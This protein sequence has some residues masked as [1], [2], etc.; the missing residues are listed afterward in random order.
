M[1]KQ[2]KIV[3][4]LGPASEDID[5]LTKMVKAGMNVA[6]LNFSHGKYENHKML[7]K[8]IRRVEEM[9]G[10]PVAILQDL[11]GPKLRIGEMPDKGL[12]LK[13]GGEIFFKTGE[14]KYTKKFIPI[15][16]P[17][18]EKHLQIGERILLDD[19]KMEVEILN[20]KKGQIK[21]KV[22][23]GGVL[24]SKKGL[25]LPDSKL[26]ISSLTEKDKEDLVFGVENDVD[27]MA[28]S[29]VTSA[30]DILDLRYLIKEAEKKLHKKNTQPIRIIAK[31]E[32]RE[33][34]ENIQEILDVADGI[35]V[36]RGDLGL[37][38]SAAKVPLVQKNLIDKA[39]EQAK[40]V[41]VATQML[42]SM[43]HN[44]RPTRAEVSDVAN[45]VIDHTD[46]VMLSNET[47]VGKYPVVVVETMAEIASITEKSIYDDLKIEVVND[48]HQNTE[49]IDKTICKMSRNLAEQVGA[50]VILVASLSGEAGRLISRFRPNL[51][52]LVATASKRIQ[53]QLNLSRGV[54][55]FIL[56]E[57]KSIEELVDRSLLYLKKHHLVKVDDKIVVVAGEP[58][59]QAGNINLLEVRVV[60]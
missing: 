12:E 45:A 30:K 27:M 56:P 57:C 8:N 1:K 35:M 26:S 22:N 6:R 21:A 60:E 48:H 38:I 51:P 13:E 9:T 52:I 7:I 18:L 11:Q 25:N 37:E 4:T 15:V 43:Q 59:G 24:F 58:V 40:P 44:P 19:G 5:T 33:A 2:T 53:H 31:I 14:K 39:L 3:C 47:A 34:V 20:I 23:V 36:A 16:F 42:D 41:I 10:E 46:A 32:R 17:D 50:K 55:P 28:I 29:F 49:S 54:I